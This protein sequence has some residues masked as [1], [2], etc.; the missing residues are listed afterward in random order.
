[1]KTVY[2][3]NTL[4]MRNVIHEQFKLAN[5]QDSICLLPVCE[6][7]MDGTCYISDLMTGNWVWN[8]AVRMP[9]LIRE[10]VALSDL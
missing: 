9:V 3:L 8:K 7:E 1:M 2:K 5:L 10:W 6:F 4:D